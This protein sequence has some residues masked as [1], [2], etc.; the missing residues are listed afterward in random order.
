[1]PMQGYIVDVDPDIE[2]TMSSVMNGAKWSVWKSQLVRETAALIDTWVEKVKAHPDELNVTG[3]RVRSSKRRCRHRLKRRAPTTWT[4][5]PQKI[6]LIP[7][8]HN[9]EKGLCFSWKT[10]GR[11]LVRVIAASY[12]SHGGSGVVSTV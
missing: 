1:M 8:K 6:A 10:E 4:K 5:M 2:Q 9:M 7:K 3:Y 12:G 11:S